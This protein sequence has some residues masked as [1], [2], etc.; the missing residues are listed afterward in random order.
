[1][2]FGGGLVTTALLQNIGSI[3]LDAYIP[4]AGYQAAFI[5]TADQA[6][7]ER[8]LIDIDHGAVGAM[9]CRHWRLPEPMGR[10][11][12]RHHLIDGADD[13][14]ACALHVADVI[15]CELVPG[16]AERGIVRRSRSRVAHALDT[17]GIV[18]EA[19]LVRHAAQ[20]LASREIAVQ[21]IEPIPTH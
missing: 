20:R 6:A 9:L 15:V 21:P 19:E 1:M 10:A 14:A 11:I 5:T 4:S 3:V 12:E 13:P 17:L 7:A 8:E 2:Q 18:D 16:V